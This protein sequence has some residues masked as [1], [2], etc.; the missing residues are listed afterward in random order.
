MNKIR[1]N[2]WL[3]NA[4]FLMLYVLL[5]LV[6]MR[7][8]SLEGRFWAEDGPIFFDEIFGRSFFSA[9]FHIVNGHL[10]IA[11]NLVTLVSTLVPFKVSP[12]VMMWLAFSFQTIPICVV[13]IFRKYLQLSTSLLIVFL[14]L[15]VALPSSNEVWAN[16]AGLHFH[17]F[18]LAALIFILRREFSVRQAKFMGL[19]LLF[20][21][22]SSVPAN[23]ICVPFLLSYIRSKSR[24]NLI[25]SGILCV[26]SAVQ[27]ICLIE[28]GDEVAKRELSFSLIEYLSAF[29][30]QVVYPIFLGNHTAQVLADFLLV[31]LTS[32]T[33]LTPILLVSCGALVC[34]FLNRT[35]YVV[36]SESLMLFLFLTV[37]TLFT[38]L[39]ETSHL[40][41]ANG[42]G[43]YFYILSLLFLL[44]F[45]PSLRGYSAPAAI[46]VCTILL[47]SS[48]P[49]LNKMPIGTPWLESISKEGDLIEIWPRGFW[50]ERRE[51]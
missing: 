12:L 16:V 1:S 49:Y 29:F 25:Y 7:E 6:K 20:C 32:V 39:G 40:I 30:A 31:N 2:Q 11:A 34:M 27:V 41:T 48:L 44:M 9:V 21:G 14:C 19:V 15:A 26:T 35:A 43:R 36:K 51:H 8:F 38:A 47:S 28:F 10:E 23:F 46:L 42:G 50:V 45:L 3:I 24:C 18:F 17:L 13:I 37:I 4:L 22:L 5:A 33:K